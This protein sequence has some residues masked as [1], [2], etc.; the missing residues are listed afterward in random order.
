MK[1]KGLR[2]LSRQFEELKKLDFT[3]AV[4]EGGE[5]LKR[6]SM[7]NAPVDTGALKASHKILK[8]E[9]NKVELLVDVIYSGIVE[10]RQPYLRRALD[11]NERRI[12]RAIGITVKKIIKDAI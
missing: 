4:E 1:I 9:K 6:K 5:V 12:A 8:I 11:T 3:E 10:F 7:I 2:N